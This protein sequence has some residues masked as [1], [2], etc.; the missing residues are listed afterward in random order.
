MWNLTS[1]LFYLFVIVP[2]VRHWSVNALII[3][4]NKTF[5]T[6]ILTIKHEILSGQYSYLNVMVYA[7]QGNRRSV[8]SEQGMRLFENYKMQFIIT[9]SDVLISIASFVRHKAN[10]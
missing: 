10:W 5:K 8:A 2:H 9:A 3:L 7:L 4:T 6:I 1:F